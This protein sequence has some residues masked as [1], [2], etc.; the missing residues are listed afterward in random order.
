MPEREAKNAPRGATP[1][2]WSWRY[3]KRIVGDKSTGLI[4][5]RLLV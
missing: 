2:L 3:L 1:W 4:D 5:G